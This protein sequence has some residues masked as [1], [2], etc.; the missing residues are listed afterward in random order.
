[1]RR[2]IL[3]GI[4]GAVMLG[5]AVLLALTAYGSPVRLVTVVG[6]SMEPAITADDLVALQT[7]PADELRVGDIIAFRP[8]GN[9]DGNGPCVARRI[10]SIDPSG[11]LRVKGDSLPEM[12]TDPVRPDS[13]AGKVVLTIPHGGTAMRAACSPVGYLILVL[14]PGIIIISDEM[15]NLRRCRRCV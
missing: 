1:M 6:N 12:D 14:L 3:E 7:V 8:L 11:D 2:R 10:V 15:E 5:A 4:A 13:V 9:G